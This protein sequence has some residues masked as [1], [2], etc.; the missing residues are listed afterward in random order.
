MSADPEEELCAQPV[1]PACRARFVHR[2]RAGG[3]AGRSAS[4]SGAT[5]GGRSPIQVGSPTASRLRSSTAIRRSGTPVS[6]RS[7][8]TPSCSGWLID[9]RSADGPGTWSP[10]DTAPRAA[11]V[12]RPSRRRPAR[13]RLVT[14]GRG[15]PHG[16]LPGAGQPR[17]LL[18]MNGTDIAVIELD[19]TFGRADQRR[20]SGLST[21]R[22]CCP[23]GAWRSNV[24]VPVE[25]CAGQPGR[26]ARS[27]S[28]VQ[29]ATR[30]ASIEFGWFFD[31]AQAVD[32][33]GILGGSSGSPLFDRTDRVV[34]MINTTTVGAS[35][36]WH[37]LV[38]QARASGP[39][40]A[41][42]PSRTRATRSRSPAS[43][44]AS[45]AAV[46]R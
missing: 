24:G 21:G 16:S 20:R 35:A 14:F 41:S 6:P 42:C 32:C 2:C 7:K 25:R 33:P 30:S 40:T 19:A 4:P 43:I 31:D 37:M 12:R 39:T 10:T 15:G 38:G 22:A 8:R 45:P 46:S 28:V 36:R 9:T 17:R 29:P 11:T 18:T 3:G 26:A 1:R 13:R 34:G 5:A 27:G 23:R 44:P